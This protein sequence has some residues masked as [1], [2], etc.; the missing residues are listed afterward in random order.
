[1]DELT[2]PSGVADP[3]RWYG[4]A[5][6]ALPCVLYSMD[7]VVLYL[8]APALAQ[9][10]HASGTELLWITDI[11]GFMLAGWLIPMGRLGDRIGRRRLL[12]IGAAAF[13]ALSILA[14][15][16]TTPGMLIATRALLGVAAATLAPSTLSLISNMFPDPRERTTAIGIWVMS[17]STGAAI[18]PL[19]GGAM[20]EAFWWGSV[21]LIAVPVMGLLLVL[22]PRLIPEFRDPAPGRFDAV[23]ALLCLVAVLAVIY[24]LKD[25]AENGWRVAPI[26][27]VVAGV[28]L[29]VVFVRRQ[30]RLPDPMIDLELFRRPAFVAAL[31][32]NTLSFVVN[33]GTF[34]LIAQY[35]QLV[36]G[37]SPLV[38]GLWTLPS[39]FGFIAGALVVPLLVRALRPGFVVAAGLAVAAAGLATVGQAGVS[40]GLA[41]VVSGSVLL[42]LGVAPVITLATDLVVGTVPPERA[43]VA[44]GVSETGSELGGALG[45]ALLGSIS[46]AVYRADL[47]HSFV[48]VDAGQAET[49]RETLAGAARI[50]ADLPAATAQPLLAA[51][52]HAFTHGLATAT[53]TGAVIAVVGACVAAVA[54]RRV[55]VAAAPT[56]DPARTEDGFPQR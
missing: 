38:A 21:F 12:L 49:A 25:F 42:A 55:G 19:V 39:A 13:G 9:D 1:M 7:L 17:F 16:S 45:I 54:L 14:A 26:V 40:S 5:M 52:R 8:A 33:F 20:L 31:G 29:A 24:G 51:S 23:S 2:S 56:E 28:V 48:G 35:F 50:A 4:L 46:V 32:A 22:G 43:G 6:I 41:V 3:R 18:G 53:L 34:L 36:L 10:L 47:P 44:S 15:F 30:R 27:P 11:Y 37:R